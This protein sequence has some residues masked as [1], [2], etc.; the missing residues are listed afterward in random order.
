M[1]PQPDPNEQYGTP[2]DAPVLTAPAAVFLA[3][4]PSAET[5]RVAD[6]ILRARPGSLVVVA[7]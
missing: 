1:L 2:P 4:P 3:G 6:S 7:S 5:E